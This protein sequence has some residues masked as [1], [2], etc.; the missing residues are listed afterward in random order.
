MMKKLKKLDS[1]NTR[2]KTVERDLKSV[3][4]SVEFALF[5]FVLAEI[6]ELKKDNETRKKTDET[7]KEKIEKVG[8][9][10]EILNKS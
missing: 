4:E 5:E 9:E 10:N 2:V 8:K 3:K 1:I 6:R 7:T